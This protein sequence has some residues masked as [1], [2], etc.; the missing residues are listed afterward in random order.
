[1]DYFPW[2]TDAQKS[3][4]MMPKNMLTKSH[5]DWG[6]GKLEETVQY[7]QTAARH[8]W[9]RQSTRLAGGK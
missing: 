2:W 1:M 4:L 3:W 5:P 6:E 7:A 9:L 8:P